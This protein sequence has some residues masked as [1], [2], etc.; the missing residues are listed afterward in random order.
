MRA[1]PL[2]CV[3]VD[4]VAANDQWVSVIA[5]GRYEELP[6]TPGCDDLRRPALELPQ[7]AGNGPWIGEATPQTGGCDDERRLAWQVLKALPDWW[8][9]AS[10]VWAS[11]AHRNPA[12]PL[13]PVYYRIR[14][15][16][17]TGHEAIRDARD[18]ISSAAAA[19][20][21]GTWGWLCRTLARVF[22]GGPNKAGPVS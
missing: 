8:Q 11:R 14:I 22:G 16:R 2:V 20:P 13:T 12:E 7:P 17:V 18:A 21:A 10:T 6:G 9:P 4:E 5:F 15:D 3:E 19:P 1:N